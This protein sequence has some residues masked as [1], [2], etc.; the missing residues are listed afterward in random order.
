MPKPKKKALLIAPAII[1]LL[2]V[3]AIFFA[4]C[5]NYAKGQEFLP[6]ESFRD[7]PGITEAEIRAVEEV[8]ADKNSFIYGMVN[9]AECFPRE[10]GSIG[11][12]AAL[13]CDWLSQLFGADFRPGIYLWSDLREGL[14]SGAIDFSG[15]YTPAGD[16]ATSFIMTAAISKRAIE[17]ARLKGSLTLDTIS[18]QRPIR[19]GFLEGSAAEVLTRP[20]LSNNG[21]P[22]ATV[23][24]GNRDE[25]LQMLRNG[26]M[27]VFIADSSMLSIFH[28]IQDIEIEQFSP[29]V[30]KRVSLTSANAQLQPLLDVLDKYFKAGGLNHLH[31]LY[32]EGYAEFNLKMFTESL[33]ETEKAYYED[34]VKSGQPILYSISSDNY[35]IGFYDK[36]QKQWSGIA[37]DVLD[38]I[39]QITGLTFKPANDAN[40]YWPDVYSLLENGQVPM[41]A[42]LLYTASREGQF[43][44]TDRP[45]A[46][47]HFALI[48]RQDYDNIDVNQILF[49]RVGLL[50]DTGYAEK[51]KEWFPD[52]PDIIEYD[53]ITK[54]LTALER[55][56]TD[57]LMITENRFLTIT[58]YME[59]SGFKINLIFEYATDSGFGFTLQESTLQGIISKAQIL[60]DTGGIANNWT[61]RVFDYQSKL[62]R[63]QNNYMMLLS[64]LLA[65]ILGLF[66][67]LFIRRNREAQHLSL[68]VA[69][70][71]QELEKQTLVTQTH[72]LEV[73]EALRRTRL[74][75]DAMPLTCHLWDSNLNMFDCNEANFRLF[76]IDVNDKQ[77]FFERFA[78]FSPKYQPD[79]LLSSDKVVMYVQEAFEEGKIVF[80]WMHQLLDGTPIPCEMT[81]VRVNYDEGYIVAAY[82]R[83]LRVHKQ[84]M[85]ETLRLQTE[86][87]TA[88]K[89]AQE[90]SM[91]K[92][93]FLANM[94]HEMRTPMNAVIGFS[95][96]LL[97]NENQ[98]NDEFSEGI[99]KIH[100]AGVTLLSII[101]DILDIS[102]IESGK[103]EI[104]PEDY[105]LP[106]FINDTIALNISRIA[107][108]PIKLI[109][110]INES[111]PS[112]LWGDCL[113]IKQIC[114][115]LL[116]NAFKYTAEGEVIWRIVCEREADSDVVWMTLSVQDTGIGIREE[117]VKKLFTDYNQLDS[118]SNRH[119]EGT[120]L[121]LA[122][123]KKMAQML[124][125][126]ISVESEYGKGSTFT[127]RIRQKHLTDIP[128]GPDI[129][130]GLRNF[131]YGI[132]K[133]RQSMNLKR[134]R[135]PYAK[136][137]IVDDLRV[138]L[139]IAQGM[140]KPYGMQIDCV[141][142]GAD[143]IEAVRQEKVRYTAIF[144]DH[145]MPGM[146]GVE[147]TRIIRE[148]IGTEYAK[149]IPIIVLTANAIAGN[150]EMF[151]AHG[152]QAFL[153]KPI[154]IMRLDSVIR[155]WVRD[156]KLEEAMAD[157]HILV[158]GEPVL[159][160]RTGVDRR[161]LETRRSGKDRRRESRSE[162][163]QE[164]RITKWQISGLKLTDAMNKFGSE[165][166]LL[167]V[168]HVF[169]EDT[170]KLLAQIR[171]VTRENLRDYMVIVHGIKGSCRG[172]FAES[173]ANLADKLEQAARE[174]RYDY[175]A[176]HNAEFI[177][178]TEALL[179]S[180]Q[181]ML[182]AETQ[183]EKKEAPDYKILADLLEAS[184]RFDIDGV[185]C[186]MAEL[187]Q[188]EYETD[189][190]L[191]RW[192]RETIKVMGFQDVAERL[193]QILSPKHI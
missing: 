126:S 44:W 18:T 75:L 163:F 146:D 147:A 125:G 11:G 148:E 124:G 183:K 112:R 135:L 111:L 103:F 104:Q 81:L 108:K 99:K 25:A 127:A 132:D 87:K 116:S 76:E 90:S 24:V 133:R 139:E 155:Q 166:T 150:E 157:K 86:L 65:I 149:N 61:H 134:I 153:S 100:T 170:P 56:E 168:L 185:D 2:A 137:L 188:Y 85:A 94:S 142:S 54:A 93:N 22:F 40:A 167:H 48:S 136:I 182:K 110:D 16:Q 123:A 34:H 156:K 162:Q 52:H 130:E 74:L 30:F 9:S 109:L 59:R 164:S 191:I 105:D 39:S 161:V 92:S 115:N 179:A 62:S 171:Q 158:N 169:A 3:M 140:M 78:N 45:Y 46:T 33:N 14:Q 36:T 113:R 177:D 128:I 95:E 32:V 117:D 28:T 122:L 49:S 27:D 31:K 8:L 4:S 69:E 29:L 172:I 181:K 6:P 50:K 175:V 55:K 83:D 10:D 26:E 53:N 57:L 80:E 12:Y 114:T 118:Q 79:G 60:V 143:A 189:A 42:E 82:A 68:L 51:F 173:L 186:A 19:Y 38:E 21:A 66:A 121:G 141:T 178:N 1:A 5:M 96:L 106:S 176:A 41:T 7:I 64:A 151:L 154:D 77:E 119:I 145:M 101:N 102:K 138:N 43:L 144:M 129:A 192:L 88:L 58:N 37:V 89:E 71:T 15:D 180:L 131:Q 17:L 165:E 174:E 98:I 159:D 187:D 63:S 152:F 23:I 13:I 97:A 20:H 190:E 91:A 35:P 72:A 47:N 107:E 160:M 193:S 73:Q 67:W 70:R 84:M 184:K 120:G